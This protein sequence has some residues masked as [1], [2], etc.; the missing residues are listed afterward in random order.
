MSAVW[1][2]SMGKHDVQE[3]V[4]HHGFS[5][6]AVHHAGVPSPVTGEAPAESGFNLCISDSSDQEDLEGAVV[7]FVEANADA[8]SELSRMGGS[9]EMDIA[10]HVGTQDS[11]TSSVTVSSHAL[12]SLTKEGV[13]LRISAYPCM[14]EQQGH[15]IVTEHTIATPSP[16]SPVCRYQPFR[17]GDYSM[18]NL[19]RLLVHNEVRL[20]SPL[21]LNDPFECSPQL[22]DRGATNADY[23][24]YLIS[25]YTSS[26]LGEQMT[27][28]QI[29]ER[30]RKELA[31][32]KWYEGCPDWKRLQ[33]ITQEVAREDVLKRT[34]ILS[35][36]EPGGGALNNVRLWGLYAD[37]HRGVCLT[38]DKDV[39][40]GEQGCDYQF[41]RVEY[42]DDFPTIKEYLDA[43]DADEHDREAYATN[44]MIILRKSAEWADENEYRMWGETT[45]GAYCCLP[46]T[47]L[48]GIT[49]GCQFD[50]EHKKTVARWLAERHANAELMPLRRDR[51]QRLSQEYAVEIVPDD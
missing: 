20:N 48:T 36:A 34:G 51:A 47:A 9:S 5:P 2:V 1:R 32:N 7:A 41:G 30:V 28:E 50:L 14:G 4:S 8:F 43:R 19:E 44:K 15:T 18:I 35:F 17:D 31:D 29:T 6:C 24:S 12:K 33:D 16:S 42:E 10:L 39:L 49:F 13:Q 23:E 46:S 27:E 38:F 21:H 37:G 40:S 3:F 26:S 45:T 22:S 11:F 25:A